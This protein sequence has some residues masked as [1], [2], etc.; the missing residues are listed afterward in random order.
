M[1]YDDNNLFA[2]ILRDEIPCYKIY[3][4]AYALAFQDINPQA[5][6]HVLVIPK[7]SYTSLADFGENANAGEITGFYRAVSKVARELN[8][9]NEGFRAIANAGDNGGQEVGHF[10]LH[11][12]GGKKLGAMVAK[13]A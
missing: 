7:G 12:L 8:L 1:A 10:H 6:V 13:A 2:K 11:L 4:D 9:T 3:E 5:P